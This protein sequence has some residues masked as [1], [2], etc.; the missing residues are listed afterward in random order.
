[1]T[2]KRKYGQFPFVLLLKDITDG[3]VDAKLDLVI[4][5]AHIRGD[6]GC[7]G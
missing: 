6:T 4:I 1:M 3:A 7:T 2:S 5:K